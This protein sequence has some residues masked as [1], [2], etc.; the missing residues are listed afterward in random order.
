MVPEK[1]L[2]ASLSSTI[3]KEAKHPTLLFQ[4]M[5]NGWLFNRRGQLILPVWDMGYCFT[6]F[7][8][9]NPTLFYFK[10]IIACL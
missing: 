9:I 5:V 1:I 4:G 8:S 10:K 3:T 2:H 7:R 6:G